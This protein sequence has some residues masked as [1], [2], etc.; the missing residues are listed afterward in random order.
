MFANHLSSFLFSD[1][2]RLG[3]AAS[4][5]DRAFV[6][7]VAATMMPENALKLGQLLVAMH[8]P[9]EQPKK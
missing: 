1:S 3:E 6:F 9:K 4:G 8:S 2:V 5:Q 7:H